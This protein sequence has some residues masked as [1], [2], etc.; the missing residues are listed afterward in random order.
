MDNAKTHTKRIYIYCHTERDCFVVSQH[1]SESRHQGHLKLG[2]KPAQ[3]YARLIIIPLSQ[4]ATHVNS[5][6]KRHY[7]VALIC[8]HFCLSDIYIYIYI[9]I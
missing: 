1:L 7:V 4:Q 6:I 8:L 9:Y 5:G 3:I 2:S